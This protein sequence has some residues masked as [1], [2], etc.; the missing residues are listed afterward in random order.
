LKE[1]EAIQLVDLIS[2]FP[3]AVEQSFETLEP[4]TIVNY[5]FKLSHA[6]SSASKML[7]VKDVTDQQLARARML[8]FWSARITLS[9]GLRLLGIES[10]KHM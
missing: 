10:I 9:N 3:E 1:K 7:R 2:K 5:L 8:M 4:S 6:T